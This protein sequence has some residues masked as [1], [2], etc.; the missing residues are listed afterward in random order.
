MWKTL[1]NRSVTEARFV[2]KNAAEA[3][4]LLLDLF[5]SIKLTILIMNENFL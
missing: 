3:N 2:V 4:G 5:L 1:F